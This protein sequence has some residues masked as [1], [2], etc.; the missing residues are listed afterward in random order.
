[1]T[2]AATTSSIEEETMTKLAP[3]GHNNPPDPIDTISAQFEAYYTEAENWTD[4]TPVENEGQMKAVDAIREGMRKFRIALE[5]GQKDATEP[6]RAVYQA[7]LD[8]WK[9][10]IADAKRIE[11]CLV[12]VVDGFKRKLAAEKAEAER[13]A[14]AEAEAAAQ[15]LREA[16]AKANAADLEAQRALAQAE[17]EAEQARIAAAVAAKSANVKGMVTKTLYEITDHRALLNWI[18]QNCRDDLTAFIE[19]WARKNHAMNPQ[20]AGLRVW[21]EKVAR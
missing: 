12:A 1:M 9:P 2:L 10:T 18:A 4:G 16:H 3:I 7:E 13:K 11:G 5:K 17:H 14:R 20:A 6:L 8:R 15:A 21:T 19:E